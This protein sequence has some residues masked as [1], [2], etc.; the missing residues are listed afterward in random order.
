MFRS[1]PQSLSHHWRERSAATC[2]QCWPKTM[3]LTVNFPVGTGCRGRRKEA[4]GGRCLNTQGRRQ[5]RTR[6]PAAMK[7]RAAAA[8]RGGREGWARLTGVTSKL[9]QDEP[10]L[11]GD[12]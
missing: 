6:T 7:A 8:L 5:L 2:G 3:V 11:S 10:A 9:C 12:A 4:G 1:N